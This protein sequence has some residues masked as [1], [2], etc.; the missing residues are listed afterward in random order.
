MFTFTEPLS[1]QLLTK[2]SQGERFARITVPGVEDLALFFYPEDCPFDPQRE[3][4]PDEIRLAY[5][6]GGQCRITSRRPYYRSYLLDAADQESITFAMLMWEVANML[7]ESA[8]LKTLAFGIRPPQKPAP[9]NEESWTSYALDMRA[10]VVPIKVGEFLGR[11]L[12]TYPAQLSLAIHNIITFI[13][14]NFR[15]DVDRWLK[16]SSAPIDNYPRFYPIARETYEK[17]PKDLDVKINFPPGLRAL[18]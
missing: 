13:K 11:T 10:C 16:G 8:D 18:Y 9:T 15:S 12:D 14:G 1:P 2:L 17:I 6:A 3:I 7:I 4:M 5:G